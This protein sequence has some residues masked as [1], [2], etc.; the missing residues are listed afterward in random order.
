MNTSRTKTKSTLSEIAAGEPIPADKL[1]Y[2]Q[3]R[4]R[5][6]LYSFVMTKF[7]E[8]ERNGRL[9]RAE[10]ARRIGRRP[11]QI[12]RLLGAPGNWTLDTA[13]DLLLGIAAEELELASS[14]LLNRKSRNYSGPDW[15][16]VAPKVTMSSSTTSRTVA[17][18]P[19]VQ[20][21]ARPA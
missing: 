15:L 21:E 2:F 3:A 14:P 6:R 9:T 7:L 4:F 12:T 10:L 19:D 17:I 5:N 18:N 20:S 8:A 1:A 16:R 13:S 11:E